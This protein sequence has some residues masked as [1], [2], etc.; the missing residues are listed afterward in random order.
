MSALFR[1]STTFWGKISCHRG[2]GQILRFEIKIPARGTL[3]NFAIW[4]QVS[5]ESGSKSEK[6]HILDNFWLP[7]GRYKKKS[8]V[9]G[10]Q[11]CTSTLPALAEK[12]SRNRSG[13]FRW[14]SPQTLDLDNSRS[15][16]IHAPTLSKVNNYSFFRFDTSGGSCWFQN[17]RFEKLKK[18]YFLTSSTTNRSHMEII[19]DVNIWHFQVSCRISLKSL[20][21]KGNKILTC[22]FW[23]WVVVKYAQWC[24]L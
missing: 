2:L 6:S 5:P 21:W 17:V 11:N 4:N 23:S 19:F 8:T 15:G 20:G 18:L 13:R 22:K 24:V 14:A 16:R 9:F 12:K 3:A 10:D 7:G 1:F